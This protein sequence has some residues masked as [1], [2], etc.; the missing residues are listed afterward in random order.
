MS[1][2]DDRARP[3]LVA[4]GSPVRTA[5]FILLAYAAVGALGGAVWEAIW[6]PPG[7]VVTQHQVFYDSYASL[8]RVFTGTGFYV[9]VGAIGSAAVALV[10]SLLTRSRELLTLVLVILGSAIAA[11]VMLKVGTMLGPADPASLAAHT[12]HRTPVSG[13]LTVEGRSVLGIKSPYLIWPTTSLL[14]LALVFF[15]WPRPPL[16]H[17]HDH[18]DTHERRPR[19]TLD[20]ELPADRQR[21]VEQIQSARFTPTRIRQG[22]D[23]GTVDAMLDR[24]AEAVRRGQTLGPVLDV[25]L[26]TVH[27]REGYDM[28][29]VRA[30]L[31]GLRDSADGVE[32]R[33]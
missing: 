1:E 24:A 11:G 2:R 31:D 16:I 8:R 13:Q 28:T 6:T 10:V 25:A 18:D 22:Y 27:W 23:M 33:R 17:D 5:L 4:P 32:P 14:V 26:P 20:T 21:L 3:G 9:V 7:Q 15:A 19:A 30:F 12:A 29:E